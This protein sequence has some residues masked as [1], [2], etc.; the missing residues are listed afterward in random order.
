ML[1]N[2]TLD[3]KPQITISLYPVLE[4]F[5]RYIFKTPSNQKQIIVC[6]NQDLG[7][8]IHSNVI[9]SDLTIRRPFIINPVT[10]ILPVN[11]VNK[12]NI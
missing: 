4:A 8:L 2:V 11:K 5:C 1:K 9:T 12:F 3:T 7:K 6:R 10:F